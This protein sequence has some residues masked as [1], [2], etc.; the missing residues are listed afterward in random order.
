MIN[1]SVT[2]SQSVSDCETFPSKDILG[3]L[4]MGG[5]CEEEASG[6]SILPG[7]P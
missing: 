5:M 7:C 3:R 6:L 4:C 2:R 1:E